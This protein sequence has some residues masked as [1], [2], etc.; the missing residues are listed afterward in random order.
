MK[1]YGTSAGFEM[2]HSKQIYL[3]YRDWSTLFLNVIIIY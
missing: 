1:P 3:L 2:V